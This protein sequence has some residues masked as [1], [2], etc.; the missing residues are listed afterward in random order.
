MIQLLSGF[1][2]LVA[3]LFQNFRCSCIFSE[4]QMGPWSFLW[5]MRGMGPPN[6]TILEENMAN[7]GQPEIPW[8]TK[9]IKLVNTY[10][11]MSSFINYNSILHPFNLWNPE[12]TFLAQH[13]FLSIWL[14]GLAEQ[15]Y[16]SRGRPDLIHVQ[17]SAGTCVVDNMGL[18]Q[19]SSIYPILAGWFTNSLKLAFGPWKMSQNHMDILNAACNGPR[20]LVISNGLVTENVGLM[21][22]MIA[23]HLL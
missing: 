7:R 5:E 2:L 21:F 17:S 1:G 18:V 16:G 15:N 9:K 14:L 8:K 12:N 22:P 23:S 11:Y 4:T 19:T 3:T 20:N 13:L 6:Q 10:H